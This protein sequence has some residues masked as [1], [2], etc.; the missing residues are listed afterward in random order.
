M[1]ESGPPMSKHLPAL[2]IF[3]GAFLLFGLQPLVGRTLLPSFGGTAAVWVV[4]LCAYQVLLLA[5]YFYAHLMARRDRKGE[6]VRAAIHIGLLGLA[7][8]WTLAFAYFRPVLKAYIGNSGMP[9]LEVLFCVLVFVGLPYVLL[10]ANSSLVQFWL[11]QGER[12][13]AD[14]GKEAHARSGG[15]TFSSSNVYRLYAV[16]NLGSFCGLL[17][18]P[19]ILEPFISLA[20]QWYGFAAGLA[21]YAILLSR[22]SKNLRAAA[23]PRE[24]LLEAESWIPDSCPSATQALWLVLPATSVFLL[25][26]VTAHLTLD[27]MPLPLL[28]VA[29]LGAFLLSYVVGF[30]DGMRRFIPLFAGITLACVGCALWNQALTFGKGNF[31]L[32]L[33]AGLGM[34]FFGCAF[35]HG[36][37]YRIR[38]GGHHLTRFYL[39]NALGG[40][41]GGLLAS[42]VAPLVFGSVTEYPIALLAMLGFA[43]AYVFRDGAIVHRLAWRV[44]LVAVILAFVAAMGYK[45]VAPSL[46]D[47]I[48]IYRAR[49]FFGVV[50]VFERRGKK[51]DSE[52][53]VRDFMHGTT[54]HGIE[55]FF[56]D[57]KRAPSTYYTPDSGGVGVLQHPKYKTGQPMRVG[58]VGMGVGVI[59]AYCRS[60]DV[61]RCYEISPEVAH[62][63]TNASLFTFISGAPGKVEVVMGDARKELEKERRAHEAKFDVLVID[64]FTG[65]N[66]PYHL[67]TREAYQLY[68]DRLEP[69][70]ILA[71]NISNWHLDLTPLMKAIGEAFGCPVVAIQQTA[72]MGQLRMSSTWAFF[73]PRPDPGFSL[74]PGAAILDFRKVNACALPTDERGS[75]IGLIN[76]PWTK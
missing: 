51:G 4:C 55:A 61:Y 22:L 28:W 24:D 59:C 66:I 75:F 52:G 26:A 9:A 46:A 64:P 1:E 15:E 74:P 37:L 23:S 45:A 12:R 48:C 20:A 70:G 58:L 57:M 53:V 50:R 2:T 41:V 44:T 54:L 60:N 3:L 42:L 34:C 65:D 16:S 35:L 6:R 49:G 18:Y 76:T 36:W 39:F 8:V 13:K 10:S 62:V 56:P 27:V 30:K 69:D 43:L 33:I 31:K 40:A 19:F 67:S 71:I 17:F 29:L 5:G 68:F 72:D 63:A 38:P 14:G 25:N 7:V 32:A 47:R 21:C 73:V 11:I